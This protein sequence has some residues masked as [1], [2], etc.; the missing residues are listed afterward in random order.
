[1]SEKRKKKETV[2]L[3]AAEADLGSLE[4]GTL[5][6]VGDA[7]R[8]EAVRQLLARSK[9]PI[10]WTDDGFSIEGTN[11]NDAGLAVLC[12]VHHPDAPKYTITIY[13]GNS[14]EALSNAGILWFYG[15]SL[16]VYETPESGYD[17][18]D[19]VMGHGS[20]GAPRATVVRRM[21]FESS[22]QFTIEAAGAE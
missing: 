19:D 14:P 10:T 16:L 22:H 1:V 21:D 7:A 17:P 18:K 9:C 2:T 13:Y 6:I 5:V 12:T 4:P 11:Y 20:S 8:D 15:N 3:T